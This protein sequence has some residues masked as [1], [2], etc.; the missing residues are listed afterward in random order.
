MPTMNASVCS[1]GSARRRRSTSRRAC[2]ASAQQLVPQSWNRGYPPMVVWYHRRMPLRVDADD[3][4]LVP[5]EIDPELVDAAAWLG[6]TVDFL[7]MACNA[8]HVGLAALRKAAGCPV[9]SMIDVAV[10]E[11]ARRGWRHVGVLG[12]AG[13]PAPYVEALGAREVRHATINGTLQARVDAGIR[14]VAEGREGPADTE[15]ARAAVAA[16]A[17]GAGRGRGARVHG[18]PADARRGG[19]SQGS[20]QPSGAPGRGRRPRG[21]RRY[22]AAWLG[23]PGAL[24]RQRRP[25]TRPA[26][27]ATVRPVRSDGYIMLPSAAAEW[28]ASWTS[29]APDRPGHFGTTRS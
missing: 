3:R 11:V 4:P 22:P 7:V 21:H 2:T 26:K 1:A 24:A 5:R 16:G 20:P 15:A 19:P 9:L 6:R 8:A 18:D 25:S 10:D 17:R 13:A 28:S 29:R 23:R 27:T 14:A 12:F